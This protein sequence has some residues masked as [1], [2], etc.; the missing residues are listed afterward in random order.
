M[1]RELRKFN[2]NRRLGLLSSFLRAQIE[3]NVENTHTFDMLLIGEV[4]VV[5]F[6]S[7]GI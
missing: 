5:H 6:L 7:E 4:K 2:I 3:I 1:L